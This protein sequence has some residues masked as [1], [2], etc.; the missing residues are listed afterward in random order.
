MVENA[1]K[2]VNCFFETDEEYL[3]N[4]PRADLHF[5]PAE[6]EAESYY[7]LI[8][9]G[10]DPSCDDR[11]SAVEI[12]IGECLDVRE[13]V[14]AVVLPTCFLDDG[15]LARTLLKV[16]RA[17]PLTYDADIGMRPIELHGVIRHLIRGYY[18]RVGLL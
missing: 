16:W 2:I 8:N 9:G 6:S 4:R 18:R 7:R 15:S 12:Q 17:Q 1:R 13:D 14:M 5:S 10:G 11:C 3:S